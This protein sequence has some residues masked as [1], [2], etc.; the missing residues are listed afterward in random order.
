MSFESFENI[1]NTGP[2]KAN[3]AFMILFTVSAMAALAI[4]PFF[5]FISLAFIPVPAALLLCMNRY[6]DAVICAIAGT[7]ILFIFN[8]ILALVLLAVIAGVSFYYRHIKD[9][10]KIIKPAYSV[11]ILAAIF[12]SSI[13]I[14]LLAESAAIGSNAFSQL[15]VKYNE[16]VKNIFS[17][18]FL[19]EMRSVMIIDS[20]QLE[21]AAKQTQDMFLFMPKLFPGLL[22]VFF[23]LTGLLN[24]YFSYFFFRRYQVKVPQPVSIKEWDVPWYCC[25]GVI[26]GIVCLV[27]PKFNDAYDGIL[28]IAGYNLII[29]FGTLYLLLGIAVLWGLLER[30]KVR[31]SVKIFI[32]V[33]VFLFFGFLIIL[34]VLGLIDI[35]ANFRKLNRSQ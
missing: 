6:R 26:A 8:Y 3:L 16:S 35:W 13:L 21:T 7:V 11:L 31:N 9:K 28:D 14:Y 34:P 20:S 10:D 25:W 22:A 24:Y 30:F 12:A 29:A 19:D 2:K 15:I 23:G 1:N 33:I 27:I 4:L 17:Q 18:Q 32:I 5:G